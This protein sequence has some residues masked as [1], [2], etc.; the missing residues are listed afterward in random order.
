MVHRNA[1]LDESQIAGRRDRGRD[2]ATL[3]TLRILQTC[4]RFMCNPLKFVSAIIGL[5]LVTSSLA[6][7]AQAFEPVHLRCEYV[8][9]PLGIDIRKPRLSWRVE[10]D[11]RGQAQTAYRILVASSLKKLVADEGDLWDSG[12]VE[13]SQTLFVEYA[14]EPLESRRECFWKVQ[15]FD[16]DAEGTWSEPALWSMGLLE[17]SDWCSEYISFRD[18]SPIHTSTEQLHL[19]AARQYRKEFSADKQVKRATIYAT[20]LGIYELHLN[21][22]RVGDAFFA[23]GLDGGSF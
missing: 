5:L 8:E 17:D 7:Q 18:E 14:G 9:N 6:T 3:L 19:P 10:A 2:L 21:G 23:A 13:S 16:G 1:P 4:T 12:K 22:N 11:D 15:A 20:A